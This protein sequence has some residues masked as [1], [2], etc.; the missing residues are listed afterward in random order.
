MYDIY[1]LIIFIIIVVAI[2]Y[3]NDT[4]IEVMASDGVK[5]KVRQ[6]TPEN[7]IKKAE[8]LSNCN[9]KARLLISKM[10]ENNYPTKKISETLYNRSKNV[11]INECPDTSAG[12]TI[13]KGQ[14][15]CVCCEKDNVVNKEKDVFFVVLHELA[16][17]MSNEYGHGIEFQTNFD[18]ITKYAAKY[19]LWEIVD[20]SKENTDICGVMVTNGPCDGDSCSKKNLDKYFKEDLLESN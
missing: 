6:S 14:I 18:Y 2:L 16:H 12:Y 20:Y 5:Y 19:D 15:I 17:V 4:R 9:K 3:G 1:I 7:N 8:L 11:I 10:K 13:N